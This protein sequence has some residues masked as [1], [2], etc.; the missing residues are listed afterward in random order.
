MTIKLV[1]GKV[2]LTVLNCWVEERENEGRGAIIGLLR[3]FDQS[4]FLQ[5]RNWGH[6]S[7]GES[8]GIALSYACQAQ[9]FM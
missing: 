1:C 9:T 4:C 2:I 6:V 8:E 3:L 5:Q 7:S